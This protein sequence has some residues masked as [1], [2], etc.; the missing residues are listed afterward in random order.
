M[1]GDKSKNKIGEIR[2]P[3]MVMRSKERKENKKR[4]KREEMKKRVR[5]ENK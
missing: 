1:K 5:K 4:M 2:A 3:E